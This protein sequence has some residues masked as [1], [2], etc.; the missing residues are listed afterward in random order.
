ML[1]SAYCLLTVQRDCFEEGRVRALELA[2]GV[3]GAARQMGHFVMVVVL[4][5]IP[6]LGQAPGHRTQSVQAPFRW[7]ICRI[8]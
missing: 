5:V 1:L 3:I 2:R 4:F 8:S 6:G 7:Y